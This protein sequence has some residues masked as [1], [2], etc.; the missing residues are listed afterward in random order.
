MSFGRTLRTYWCRSHASC[1]ARA[2]KLA[3][4]ES[5]EKELSRLTIPGPVD[6]LVIYTIEDHPKTV[7]V[8]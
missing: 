8:T 4:T 7:D 6:Y 5:A 3:L 1:V 2:Y